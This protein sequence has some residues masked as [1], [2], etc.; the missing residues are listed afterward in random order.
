MDKRVGD[1]AIKIACL[2]TI[3]GQEFEVA[4]SFK[5][6][7]HDQKLEPP[8]Q[9]KGFGSFDIIMFYKTPDFGPHLTKVGRIPGILKSNLFLAFPYVV[10]SKCELFESIN[11]K[12]F[13]IVVFLKVHPKFQS[14]TAKIKNHLESVLSTFE[15]EGYILGSIG[16]NE[17]I[18][19]LC[20]NQIESLSKEALSV[21][22]CSC[23]EESLES[24][25]EGLF[26]KTHSYSSINYNKLNFPLELLHDHPA[27]QEFFEKHDELKSVISDEILVSVSISSA[28]IFIGRINEYWSKAGFGVKSILGLEDLEV[29]PFKGITW[30]Q[31]IS[32]IIHFRN[33]FRNEIQGTNTSIRTN[34]P[35]KDR[36]TCNKSI[37]RSRIIPKNLPAKPNQTDIQFSVIE[38][39]FGNQVAPML[40]SHLYEFCNL[41][42]NPIS[43]NVYYDIAKFP[44]II[45][46][47]IAAYDKKI[48]E[49]IDPKM[50]ELAKESFR[51]ESHAVLF[52][53]ILKRGAELRSYGTYKDL[54]EVYGRFSKLKGG[55]QRS[56]RALKY[57]PHKILSACNVQWNGF[58]MTESEK[59]A[60]YFDVIMVPT[61]ALWSPQNWWPLYHEIAHVLIDN[62]EGLLDETKERSIAVFLSNKDNLGYWRKLLIE[63]TAE[64]IGFE[65]GFFGNYNLFLELLWVH[66][67]RISTLKSDAISFVP[68]MF[69]GFFVYLFEEIYRNKTLQ[70]KILKDQDKLYD[71]FLKHIDH[72]S[73][74]S[75]ID[76]KERS[77]I[78][79][80]NVSALV[81]LA[82]FFQY[83][84]E[85]VEDIQENFGCL[86]N[87]Q[88]LLP[89]T[90]KDN[91][92]DILK[93]VREGYVWQGEI[94]FPEALLYDIFQFK[95]KCFRRDIAIVLTFANNLTDN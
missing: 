68:Y 86:Y 85:L 25:I 56:F 67:K 5:K 9:L 90:G 20:G 47:T 82:P 76:F 95:D 51:F 63:L 57:L 46:Q 19:V 55:G 75:G 64:V 69:R 89:G 35:T 17:F 29:I 1:N 27:L 54:E 48:K 10:S 49:I 88:D 79:G 28:P 24:P 15:N 11:S 18:V 4:A 66:L 21:S 81:E 80:N 8:V 34:A 91:T 62:G 50:Q 71:L 32:K 14:A 39:Y 84:Y 37:Y 30:G 26:L 31:L 72:V 83:L 40:S 22:R 38:E 77:F 33:L 36:L 74:I 3:P 45:E 60:H 65:L 87:S 52:C 12:F 7:C 53:E 94:D 92:S 70:Y 44:K 73:V 23:Y 42:Q 58:I 13:T 93:T 6:G 16:W 61:D 59:F 43:G 2:Q 41:I 78:A